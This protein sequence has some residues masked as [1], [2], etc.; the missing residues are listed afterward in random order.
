MTEETRADAPDK[1]DRIQ[2]SI[3]EQLDAGATAAAVSELS[4][5]RLPDQ[6]DVIATLGTSNRQ[7]VLGELSESEI[8][9]IVEHLDVE[10][11]ADALGLIAVHTMARVLEE[12]PPDVAADVLRAV[13]WEVARGI[14][15]RMEDY[16]TVSQLLLYPDD[17]AGGL[18]M[19][20]VVAFDQG[21][22]GA[23]AMQIL[24]ESDLPRQ[25]FR[26]LFAVDREGHL[27]GRL[28]MPDLVLS[29]SSYTIQAI[30]NPDVFSVET[31]T[32][33]EEVARLMAR[34]QLR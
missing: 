3:E 1:L 6:A 26:Q 28:N 17:H 32:D 21:I 18:M 8:A 31:G 20:E 12:A 15:A 2:D 25:N 4:E 22:T 33:Q 23:H 5:L 34:Y 19:P 11:A 24:R 9:N 29:P 7:K 10:D 30:M 13:D 27:V 14:L 16:Q